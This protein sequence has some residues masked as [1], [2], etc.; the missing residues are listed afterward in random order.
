MN[1]I[2]Q[3]LIHTPMLRSY[4]LSDRHSC[5]STEDSH[6]CLMCEMSLLFQEARILVFGQESVCLLY[7]WNFLALQASS[8]CLMFWN[9]NR[10]TL[11]M[12]ECINLDRNILKV[13]FLVSRLVIDYLIDFISSTVLPVVY[14]I[15]EYLE[16]VWNKCYI[17]FEYFWCRD[18]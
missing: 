6:N 18:I 5:P 2:L 15:W 13:T 12:L 7:L 17:E 4:F 8:W 11:T 10:V 3:A 1:C 16:A 9:D 14:N